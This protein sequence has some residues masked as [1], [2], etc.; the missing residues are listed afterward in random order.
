MHFA[1]DLLH[2]LEILA[3]GGGGGSGGGGGGGVLV[4]FFMAGYWP[5]SSIVEYAQKRGKKIIGVL[6]SIPVLIAVTILCAVIFKGWSI[7]TFAGGMAGFFAGALGFNRKVASL[8]KSAATQLRAAS[9]KDAA[10]SEDRL[11]KIVQSTFDTYQTDWSSFNFKRMQSYLVPTYYAHMQ[12][13]LSALYAMGR[14]NEVAN[15]KL[16]GMTFVDVQDSIDNSQDRF[17]VIIQAHANDRLIDTLD[18]NKQIYED[19]SAWQE[20][21]HFKRQ[22]SNWLLADIKQETETYDSGSAPLKQFAEQNAFFY[23]ADFGWLLLPQRGQLFSEADFKNSDVNNHVI[24]NYKNTLVEFYSYAP[25]KSLSEYYVVAQAVLPKTYGNIVV[26]R[27]KSRWRRDIKGLNK[28]SMEAR[29]FND[30]YEVFA[31]NVEQVTSFELLHPAYMVTLIELGYEVN[32][33]VT[34][35]ILYLYSTDRNTSYESMLDLLKKA[36]DEL[37]L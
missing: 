30:Q 8:A 3:R 25:A 18:N 5:I 21:W 29:E 9:S 12:L 23:N 17:A 28:I 35:N 10:W 4:F 19:S 11:R 34:D 2:T 16:D 36:F 14:R 13:V 31:D 27:I 22:G 6:V 37:K 33:E 24:G 15:A 7:V 32:I 26:R 1:A 20:T